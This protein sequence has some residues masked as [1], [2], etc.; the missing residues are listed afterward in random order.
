MVEFLTTFM[1]APAEWDEHGNDITTS[2]QYKEKLKAYQ[3]QYKRDRSGRYIL[4]PCMH[5]DLLEEFKGCPT[6]EDMWDCLK[7]QFGHTFAVRLRPCG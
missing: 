1:F 7:I 4:L 5:N 2:E 6:T 3:N